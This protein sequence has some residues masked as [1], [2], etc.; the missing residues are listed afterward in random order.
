[1]SA[2]A[3]LLEGLEFPEGPRWRDGRLWMSDLRAGRVISM[4]AGGAPRI[5]AEFDEP[6]S[7]IGFLPDST[8]LVALMTSSR[9][10]RLDGKGGFTL[11]AD[12]S[13][14]GGGF[15]NDLITAPD[16]STYVDCLAHPATAERDALARG[17]RR[18][19]FAVD[20][21]AKVEVDDQ[22]VLVDRDGGCRVV[23]D[24]LVTPNGIAISPG[25]DRL[26]VVESRARRISSFEIAR[27]GALSNRQVVFEDDLRIP[28]GLC[29]DADGAMWFASP[30]TGECVRV[31]AAG[32]V[33]DVARPTAGDR[34]SAC[35]LGGADRRTLFML[36]DQ[37]L[38]P[39]SGRIETVQVDVPGAGWP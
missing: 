11:H 10:A 29:L 8:P 7:G 39:G 24:D 17:R 19:T 14:L 3:V 22:I 27:D 16:G 28:D 5:E 35:V 12:L 15:I 33:V 1:M 37:R 6:C 18:F 34:V 13:R 32:D 36:T 2:A 31:D 38:I 26:L 4:D 9:V 25:G 21:E 23:A 20:H 30:N